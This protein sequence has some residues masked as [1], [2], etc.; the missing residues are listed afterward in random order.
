MKNK[1]LAYNYIHEFLFRDENVSVKLD[2]DQSVEPDDKAE[3]NRLLAV[4]GEMSVNARKFNSLNIEYFGKSNTLLLNNLENTMQTIMSIKSSLQEVIRDAKTAYKFVLWMYVLAFMLGIGL[5]VVAV[6]FAAQG[7]MILSI[8]FGAIGLIDIV[9]HFIFKPPLELQSSRANLTQLMIVVTNWFSDLMNL[10]T[11]ISTRGDQLTM[12]ELYDISD[13]QNANTAKMIDLI[14]RYSEPS[15]ARQ[16]SS[17]TE[18][19]AG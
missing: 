17:G 10:N 4:L 7:K 3:L 9:S 11:F 8:A 18:P 13:K 6:V 12:S 14:E 2:A 15:S 16:G 5:I 19:G 1:D